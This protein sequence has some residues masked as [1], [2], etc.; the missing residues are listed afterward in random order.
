[1]ALDGGSVGDTAERALA[2]T[3]A[4]ATTPLPKMPVAVA[5]FVTVPASRSAWVIE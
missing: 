4:D 2:L 3:V 1:M 5:V